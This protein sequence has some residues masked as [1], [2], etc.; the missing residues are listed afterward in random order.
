M[1]YLSPY[2]EA[3]AKKKAT[4]SLIEKHKSCGIFQDYGHLSPKT[5]EQKGL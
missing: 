2:I 1:A 4:K 3:L 5:E